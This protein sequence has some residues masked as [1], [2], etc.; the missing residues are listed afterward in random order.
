ME[1]ELEKLREETERLKRLAKNLEDIARPKRDKPPVVK[2]APQKRAFGIYDLGLALSA[3][4]LLSAAFK[5]FD[6]K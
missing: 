5:I 2:P 4:Y 1:K 6:R 3:G